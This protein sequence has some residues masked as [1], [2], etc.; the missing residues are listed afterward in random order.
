[1][2]AD[3]LIIVAIFVRDIIVFTDSIDFYR[4][5]TEAMLKIFPMKDLGPVKCLGIYIT[6]DGLHGMIE[7]DQTEYIQS[8]LRTFKMQECKIISTPME[9][10]TSL[11]E[12]TP[13]N[14]GSQANNQDQYPY[15]NAVGALLYLV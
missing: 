7:L 13:R 6:R 2:N 5:L 9:I 8:I 10:K 12:G 11:S 3:K 14:K 4:I 1:M 15:Q